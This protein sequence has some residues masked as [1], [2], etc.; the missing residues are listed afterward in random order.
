MS[1]FEDSFQENILDDYMVKVINEG[2]RQ[3]WAGDLPPFPMDS[4]DL[5]GSTNYRLSSSLH[6]KY[7]VVWLFQTTLNDFPGHVSWKIALDESLRLLKE[8]GKLVL[9]LEHVCAAQELVFSAVKAFLGRHLCFECETIYEKR[10]E[11]HWFIVFSVR[12][13]NFPIYSSRLWSFS[14]LT[15][16]N[17]VDRVCRF[18]ASIRK[19]DKEHEHEIIIYGPEN[20]AYDKYDVKYVVDKEK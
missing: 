17:Q 13:R 15:L 4:F 14:I 5:L 9:K 7:D 18:L 3:A 10:I 19:N 1:R 12:R 20:K 2:G 6:G 11:R 16:G 8:R